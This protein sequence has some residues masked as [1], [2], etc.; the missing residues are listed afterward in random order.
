MTVKGQ[1][2]ISTQANVDCQPRP[3]NF[4]SPLQGDEKLSNE[5]MKLDLIE[6]IKPE[7]IEFIEEKLNTDFKETQEDWN[8][9]I[10]DS[11][12][13]F[14]S[15]EIVSE[16]DEIQKEPITTDIYSEKVE[17]SNEQPKTHQKDKKQWKEKTNKA[18]K[19]SPQP[20]SPVQEEPISAWSRKSES[21]TENRLGKTFAEVL[22]ADEERLQ[23]MAA[24]RPVQKQIVESFPEPKVYQ[25]TQT[26]P[27]EIV[28]VVS[29]VVSEPTITPKPKRKKI[30]KFSSDPSFE[31]QNSQEIIESIENVEIFETI[32]P[33]KKHKKDKKKNL[34]QEISEEI[35]EETVELEIAEDQSNQKSKKSKKKR[36]FLEQNVEENDA[37]IESR[38][39]Q[40]V[41]ILLEDN[42]KEVEEV[43]KKP[44]KDKKKKKSV[45]EI[46]EPTAIV[47]D[48][49]V[50][51]ETVFIV[52]DAHKKSKKD[53]IN[54]ISQEEIVETVIE[55]IEAPEIESVEDKIETELSE[56]IKKPKKKRNK[57]FSQDPSQES[58]SSF[59]IV[60]NVAQTTT[61][62]SEIEFLVE[63]PVEEIIKSAEIE[64]LQESPISEPEENIKMKPK[65]DKKKRMSPK[66]S[67]ESIKS[68]ESSSPEEAEFTREST[69]KPKKKKS[70]KSKSIDDNCEASMPLNSELT[71]ILI[72]QE[73]NKPLN[74][75]MQETAAPHTPTRSQSPLPNTGSGDTR[76]TSIDASLKSS[77]VNYC[78][79][80]LLFRILMFVC[81][82]LILLIYFS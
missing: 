68:D 21:P 67:Q 52:E 10:E 80:L 53:K 36:T 26:A 69:K 30:K 47:E 38:F 57:K 12:V 16:I 45:D 74:N 75:K 70:K 9:M 59:E 41:D 31:S 78:K 66:K 64:L 19:S 72:Q 20:E 58:Q 44:K 43:I 73:T 76:Q 77:K 37:I 6:Q 11:D 54:K 51:E 56:L 50:F 81:L 4:D 27:R 17:E 1:A 46:D 65:K 63:N 49:I 18:K 33:S 34:S 28:E 55:Q 5:E 32:E 39:S 13:A 7:I 42:V 71:D 22:K 24:P 40:E 60:S 3:S 14:E 2:P 8:D 62:T 25:K 15:F 61:I 23:R 48:E 79:L 82:I 29:P 35:I